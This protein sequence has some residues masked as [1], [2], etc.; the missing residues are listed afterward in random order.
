MFASGGSGVEH[1]SRARASSPASG[2]RSAPRPAFRTGDARQDMPDL[3]LPRK[4]SRVLVIHQGNARGR[5]LRVGHLPRED[6][7]PRRHLGHA[8]ARQIP[9]A[10]HLGRG[11]D[12]AGP[13]SKEALRLPSSS[14]RVHRKTA[15]GATAREPR[16]R[17]GSRFASAHQRVEIAS[18]RRHRL[19][20][21]DHHRPHPGPA[22][23][24]RSTSRSSSP[25]GKAALDQG[26][27][28]RPARRAGA[29]SR[30]RRWGRAPEAGGTSTAVAGLAHADRSGEAE[31]EG[32]HRAIRS[33]SAS[34]RRAQLGRHLRAHAEPA[35]ETLLNRWGG[36]SM[37]RRSTAAR[38]RLVGPRRAQQVGLELRRR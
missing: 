16:A 21:A 17:K 29:R 20:L 30:R 1:D 19:G 18:S 15:S 26:R 28:L 38:L 12:D 37:P 8:R 23:A 9:R 22:R 36:S 27:R 35:L 24:V 14:R 31:D 7:V 34:T 33:R 10:L 25:P 4:E 32:G 5:A 3:A 13:P 2:I 11:G 6:A